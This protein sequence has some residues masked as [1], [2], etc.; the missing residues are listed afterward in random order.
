MML[1]AFDI[2]CLAGVERLRPC[3]EADFNRP[4]DGI[5]RGELARVRLFFAQIGQ[6][7][8]PTVADGTFWSRCLAAIPGFHSSSSDPYL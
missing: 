5:D 2:Q 1:A 6:H 7:E 4:T 3:P 8:M